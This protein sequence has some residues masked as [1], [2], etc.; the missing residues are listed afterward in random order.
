MEFVEVECSTRQVDIR[1]SRSFRPRHYR[2]PLGKTPMGL[3]RECEYRRHCAAPH[4]VES[5]TIGVATSLSATRH[6]FPFHFCG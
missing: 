3:V 1:T 6:R 2:S 4:S 5:I